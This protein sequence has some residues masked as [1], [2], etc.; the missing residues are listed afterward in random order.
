MVRHGNYGWSYAEVI[1]RRMGIVFSESSVSIEDRATALELAVY[2]AHAQNRFAAMET[3][4]DM[5]RGIDD[6]SL[7][8]RVG[9]TILEYSETFI[10]NIEPSECSCDAVRKALREIRE[11]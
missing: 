3:C 5:V 4:R 8:L 7:G 2:A 10:A 11:S 1:A 6:N 9:E